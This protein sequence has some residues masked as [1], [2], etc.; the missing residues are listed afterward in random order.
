MTHMPKTKLLRVPLLCLLLFLVFNSIVSGRESCVKKTIFGKTPEGKTVYLYTLTNARGA[1]VSISNYG[2]IIVSWLVPDREGK[3]DDVVLGYKT[4][5][6]YIA[7]SPYF[8]A[9][10]GRYGNRIAQGKFSIDGNNYKLATNDKENHLHG[11]L[12]GF[13]KQVWRGEEFID[14]NGPGVVLRRLSRDAEEGYPGN[15]QAEVR[16]QLAADD[17]SLRIDYRAATDKPTPVNL[18]NHSY[19]NLAGEG[20]GSILKHELTLNADRFTPVDAGLIPSGELQPVEGTPLDFRRS[21]AIGARIAADDEQLRR[22][23]GYDHNWVL[24]ADKEKKPDELT[25]AVRVCEPASGRVLEISTTEP[26]IQFYSGNFLDG[27]NV[28]KRGKAYEHRSGFCLEPQHFPDSPNQPE[29]PA[30]ILRPGEE[31]RSTSIY[32]FSTAKG[33]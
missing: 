4:L 6:E 32:R 24:N 26:G 27:S 18:T 25:P 16:Y 29:F 8:G 14:K 2:G 1:E 28:G 11:G 21:T 9:I 31:Y 3:M 10:V 15:L 20:S 22:G 7:N 33:E 12:K 19:F 23:G 13:D 30:T 5:D 17:N